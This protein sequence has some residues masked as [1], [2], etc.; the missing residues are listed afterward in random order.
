MGFFGRFVY[1]DGAWPDEP[2]GDA[3]LSV[4]IHDSDVA[5]IDFQ[6]AS[7]TGRFFLGFQPRDSAVPLAPSVQE[8]S[9]A[10]RLRSRAMGTWGVGLFDSDL[11]SD[12][13]GDWEDAL[14][15]GKSHDEA[16]KLLID[17]YAEDCAEDPDDGP[18]FWFAIAT[19]ELDSRGEVND[20]SRDRAL[21]AM[22]ADLERWRQEG[23]PEDA[24]GR[25]QILVELA[26][27]LRRAKTVRYPL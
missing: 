19:L 20:Y 8:R 11:A 22:P 9:R 13:R 7:A 5:T 3:F 6:G 2:A 23:T 1:S 24:A 4:D 16:M 18:V 15:D 14:A 12:M 27:R 26:E 25:E 10:E 17:G 21:D